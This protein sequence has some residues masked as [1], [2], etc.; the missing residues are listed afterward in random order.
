MLLRPG[1][2]LRETEVTNFCPCAGETEG[3]KMRRYADLQD[4][5]LDF[6]FRCKIFQND[7]RSGLGYTA[8]SIACRGDGFLKRDAQIHA[9]PY[10]LHTLMT[11]SMKL[12]MREVF[13]DRS[14]PETGDK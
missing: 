7:R 13:G 12:A 11:C 2:L 6:R 3:P 1:G 10:S 9:N 5:T 4:H 14:L 8:Y